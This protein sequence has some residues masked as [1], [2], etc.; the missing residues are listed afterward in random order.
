MAVFLS[1][2]CTRYPKDV[3]QA[4]ELAGDNRHELEKVLAHYQNLGERKKLKA[5]YYLIANMEGKGYYAGG[6]IDAYQ[7]LF[8]KID[9][10]NQAGASL[11]VRSEAMKMEWSQLVKTVGAPA[12]AKAVYYPD[13]KHLT[14]DFL[15]ASIDHAFMLRDSLPW[16]RQLKKSLFYEYILPY[17]VKRET[18]HE[19]RMHLF[20]K[21]RM[22]RD[23]ANF[24]DAKG[25][26]ALIN[27]YI[28]TY[29]ET[30]R[31]LWDYPF[32]F[33]AEQLEGM[34]LGA[35]PH[36]V[37]Y[38]VMAMRANGIATAIDYTPQWANM[39]G[40]HHWA[41]LMDNKYQYPYDAAFPY[42]GFDYQNYRKFAK[43]FRMSFRRT[44]GEFPVHEDIPRRMIEKGIDV[45]HEYTATA[46]IV[47]PVPEMRDKEYALI[48]TFNNRNWSPQHPGRIKA[49]N[50]EFKNMGKGVVYIIMSYDG[51]RLQTIGD[52]FLVDS[53][54][55]VHYFRA[56]E[57]KPCDMTVYRK[58]PLIDRIERYMSFMIGGRFVGSNRDD[59]QDTVLLYEIT[60]RPECFETVI[61]NEQQTFRH[62]RYVTHRLRQE[63]LAELEFYGLAGNGTD[64]V[65]LEG[66]IIG[67]PEPTPETEY[68]S[69]YK[70]FDGD[71]GNF[72]AGN[73]ENSWVGMDFG[74]PQRIV[75]IRYCPRSDTNF[76]EPGDTY[77]LF[78]W[79]DD[80]WEPTGRRV[81]M[82][83]Y[84]N[85]ENVPSGALYLLRNYT[86]GKEERIFTYEN[87]K[88]I[89]W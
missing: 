28:N 41:V 19:W 5:A 6:I 83:P 79:I 18:P 52:P 66:K 14:A 55:H 75:K 88:Q 53:L 42:F 30:D 22:I 34:G 36:R 17:R 77:E 84:L 47:V 62:L 11:E 71:T 64:T 26:T 8:L 39:Q 37:A 46:D 10:L 27:P 15:I 76:I 33:E 57:E 50:A 20:E 72:F 63:Q 3:L 82:E 54:G 48:G 4:L 74:K 78:Y 68:K 23:T 21:M 12:P 7:P 80:D 2:S 89:W 31:T 9:S 13:E 69:Y 1:V 58:F 85:Y 24:D 45:T 40:G 29:L 67:Y 65:K 86:K 70:A 61:I 35:C 44:A 60:R 51:G 43:V 38:T 59:Y 16:C 56:N 73:V 87:G 81:A 32:D 25:L 49:G